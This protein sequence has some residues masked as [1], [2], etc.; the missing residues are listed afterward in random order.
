MTDYSAIAAQYGAVQPDEV[1]YTK[2]A[3]SFGAK[4]QTQPVPNIA[5]GNP[6]V[7]TPFGTIKTP[8]NES[9]FNLPAFIISGGQKVDSILRG[10]RRLKLEAGGTVYTALGLDKQAGINAQ[11]QAD[12]ALQDEQ[13]QKNFADLEA[14]HPGSTQL[15]GTAPLL[16]LGPT[17]LVAAAG[18]E[19]GSMTDRAK[20]M[21]LTIAG[22]KLMQA[23]GNIAAKQYAASNVKAAENAAANASIQPFKDA[24][25]SMPPAQANPSL[26]NQILEGLSGGAKTEQAMS[27]AN[28]GIPTQAAKDV[29]GLPKSATLSSDLLDNFRAKQYQTGYVPVK[30]IPQFTADAQFQADVAALKPAIDKEIPELANGQIDSL[31]AGLSKPGFSGST[32]VDLTRRLRSDASKNFKAFD[33]PEKQALAQAQR[34]ASNAIEGLIERNLA[35]TGDQAKLTAFQQAR[36]KIAQAHSV[37]DA[38]VGEKVAAKELFKQYDKGKPL[39]PELKTAA[40][41][42]EKF[43]GSAQVINSATKANPFSVMD[44]MVTAG[45]ALYAGLTHGALPGLALAAGGVAAR[46]M[47]RAGLASRPYQNNMLTRPEQP[48]GLLASKALN[49]DWAPWMGGLLGYEAANR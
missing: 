31:I 25:Y 40:Q 44:A 4:P 7:N 9:G 17:G 35:A 14:I 21:G 47:L 41:F 39:A 22:N 19:D 36:Q 28:E 46:P 26:P 43:P 23:G 30:S 33:S 32:A 24:G 27:R 10:A 8:P 45:P 29:L 1:D 6:E 13:N 42:F 2:L 5:A 37:E 48:R 11:I 15:G 12:Q 16:P 49:N 18:L 20:R 34:D 3:K 38:L